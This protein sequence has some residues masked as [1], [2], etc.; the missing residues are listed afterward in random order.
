VALD[1]RHVTGYAE[2][3]RW[4]ATRNEV[5]RDD[6]VSANRMALIR[7]SELGRVD[8]LVC[9]EG[10]PVG[11][12][13]LAGDPNSLE[14]SYPYVEVTVPE[15]H[16][17]RGIGT[18]IARALS[19]HVRALGKEGLHCDAREHDAYSIAFLVRRGF[20][21]VG[22]IPLLALELADVEPEAHDPPEGVELT[23]LADRPDVLEGMFGVATTTYPEHGGHI[24]K[25]AGTLQEWQ[26]YELGDPRL[27]FDMTAV[28]LA[29]EAVVGFA[30]MV[31]LPD[32]VTG[33][34]R[35]TTVLPE[36]RRRRIGTALTCAQVAAAKRAGL[37]TLIVWQRTELTR[38]LHESLG[39]RPRAV[40]IDFH[41]PL[42]DD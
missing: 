42:L 41:G 32:G 28:A 31:R 18:A 20:T 27:L 37:G 22:R 34:H 2:L 40:S 6:P 8:L 19:Q 13:M 12:G 38:R 15:R 33:A 17:G 3:E 5:I 16:R 14:S 7:A 4:V 24:A 1:I 10:E 35:I 9:E 39:Y 30:T 23:W 26:L 25:E 11:T 21:E 29:G 36:W